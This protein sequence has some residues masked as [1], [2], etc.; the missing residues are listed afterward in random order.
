MLSHP[1]R[2]LHGTRDPSGSNPLRRRRDQVRSDSR[3]RGGEFGVLCPTCKSMKPYTQCARRE[4]GAV[5]E[6]RY[7]RSLRGTVE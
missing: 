7:A 1:I 5:S 6:H 2:F 4:E 3:R